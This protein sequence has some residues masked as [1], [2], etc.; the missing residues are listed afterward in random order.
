M[1]RRTLLL[2][3]WG[4]SFGLW[5]CDRD[6]TGL[7]PSAT[8]SQTPQTQ[9]A[10]VITNGGFETGDFTGWFVAQM[11]AAPPVPIQ[12]AGAGFDR[13]FGFFLSAP[14]EGSFAT[15]LSFERK[16]GGSNSG[17]VG[18]DIVVSA[19]APII[20]FDYRAGWI[21]TP[22]PG[23]SALRRF[24]VR[25][26]SPGSGGRRA[27]FTIF[28]VSGA[29]IVLDTGDQMGSVDL[30]PF[31][32]QTIHLSFEWS[33]DETDQGPGFFQLDN[34][35]SR[36]ANIAPVADAGPD[37]RVLILVPVRFDGSRSTDPDG[38]I[39]DYQWDFGD[40]GTASG[41]VV[42]HA[43]STAAVF[44]ATL[45]VTDDGGLTASDDV[46]IT[47]LTPS[48]GIEDLKDEVIQIGLIPGLETALLAK[49]DAALNRLAAG[50]TTAAVQLL[51]SFISQVEA[52][53]NVSLTAAQVDLL[54]GLADDIIQSILAG[55]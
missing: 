52:M 14:T 21:I 32:G 22:G 5:G 23:A 11:D 30:T 33:S 34:I 42:Q 53:E 3:L 2:S 54:R 29:Q 38:S 7:A 37:R 25:I 51:E 26:R 27:A 41:A 47:V 10:T 28:K 44:T 49:L 18:Q 35:R 45:T 12:V 46:T 17:R 36:P 39:I 8:L 24:T 9:G 4:T 55:G 15:I 31:I 16:T 50:N 43:Y 20:E 13:G 6:T 48:Q 1:S 40:G 19:A